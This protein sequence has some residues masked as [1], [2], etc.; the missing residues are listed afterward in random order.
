MTYWVCSCPGT[1][2]G[3]WDSFGG[4]RKGW[5]T[6]FC[7]CTDLGCPHRVLLLCPLL[8]ALQE[9]TAGGWTSP[10]THPRDWQPRSASHSHPPDISSWQSCGELKPF[11][12]TSL[13]QEKVME[14]RWGEKEE[15]ERG[16]WQMVRLWQSG[17]LV[18][19]ARV[20]SSGDHS[21]LPNREA[22]GPAWR[23]LSYLVDP[24]AQFS[25]WQSQAAGSQTKGFPW[26]SSLPPNCL[27]KTKIPILTK[28]PSIA[29]TPK[30]V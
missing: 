4:P 13:K 11:L 26:T 25:T 12:W 5:A 2:Q 7:I 20:S 17:C 22:L 29:V 19:L 1:H 23:V 3:K 24:S 8:H 9:Q 16:S 28:T 30:Q 10:R 21:F 14:R 15:K 6:G 27:Q 18:F